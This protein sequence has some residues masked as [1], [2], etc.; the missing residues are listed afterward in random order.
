MILKTEPVEQSSRYDDTALSAVAIIIISQA[1]EGD[2][3]MMI[4][5]LTLAGRLT[6][7]PPGRRT[8]SAYHHSERFPC[9]IRRELT[10]A[11][12]Y[13]VCKK[14]YTKAVDRR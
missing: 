13:S 2:L 5:L 8:P 1:K 12:C 9:L 6:A 10:C 11:A 3:Q 4:L 14:P 7:D